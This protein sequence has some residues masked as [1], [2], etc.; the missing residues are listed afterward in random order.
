MAKT[1]DIIDKFIDEKI[2]TEYLENV[3]GDRFS[4]YAKYIIQDR[5]L[6]DVRDGLKPVQRRILYAMYAVNM[7]YNEPYKKSARIVGE[8]IG[9][10]HP[11]GDSSVYEALVRMS[12]SFKIN[13]PLIDMHGNNGS[14][15]G[16][17]AA[18]MRYTE[19]RL[20]KAS[21]ALIKDIDKK[22]VPFIPNYDDSELEPVILP[23]KFPNLLVNGASG[24]SA[25]YATNIP[26]HN[27][28][29]TI[30]LVIARLKN[31]KLSVD[32]GLEILP[33]PDFPSGGIIERTDELR[34]AFETGRGKVVIRSKTR[35]E[36]NTIIVSEIP[37]E[38][39]K[40]LLVKKIDSIA[41]AKKIDG[42]I[43]VRDE[44]DREGLRIAIDTREEADPSVIL[45]YLLKNT[46]LQINYNYNLVAIISKGPKLMGFFEVID[47][48]ILH[49]KEIITNRSNYELDRAQKRLH[50]V[51]GYHKMSSIIDKVVDTIKNS[52]NK[53][54]AKENLVKEYGFTD[55]QAEAIVVLQLYRLTNTDITAFENEKKELEKQITNLKHILTN[56]TA[57]KNIIISELEE[58]NDSIESP[59]K[60][61]ITDEEHTID[62]KEEQLIIHEDVHVI[63]TKDGYIKK[64]NMKSYQASIGVS[65]AGLKEGDLI[66]FDEVCNTMDTLLLFLN[67]GSY[68]NL[69]VFKIPDLKYKELGA[70]I[71]SFFD[72]SGSEKIISINHLTEN[73]DKERNVLL[74]TKF[75]KIKMVKINEMLEKRYKKGNSIKLVDKDKLVSAVI[76]QIDEEEV[77]VATKLGLVLKYAKKEVPLLGS[78]AVGVKSISLKVNDEVVSTT[79]AANYYKEEAILLTNRGCLKRIGVQNLTRSKRNNRGT[80]YLKTVKTNPYNFIKHVVTNPTKYKESLDLKIIN[81]DE[82]IVINGA[83]LPRDTYEHGI[84]IITENINPKDLFFNIK[85]K[86]K[87]DKLRKDLSKELSKKIEEIKGKNS[88]ALIDELGDIIEQQTSIYDYIEDDK[89]SDDDD[90]LKDD[91]F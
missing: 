65:E 71:G 35:I 25:G 21:M 56:E 51:E 78:K 55:L 38:V 45:N 15:D 3:M 70:Y 57:L 36:K 18:A 53:Q 48:Y 67:D 91:L 63:L 83:D 50:I 40:S 32:E 64:M 82:L 20:S 12:Q 73:D 89:V 68:I 49:Q 7:V 88:D 4:K 5:A 42:I 6:P 72:M 59:R 13:V 74:A 37:Y 79:F 85:D 29:E 41:Q 58:I 16:D 39:N 14:I 47:S 17:G 43:E 46:D 77:V 66:V 80:P 33:G 8:V 34:R 10:Y 54:N 2:Q 31:P 90:K 11:H 24:I 81:N 9:K 84:P 28:H 23:A 44:S 60:T 69:P 75:G 27:L 62:F 19:A 52:L 76:E 87:Y 86:D 22:T 61:E 30:N 1:K 26:P